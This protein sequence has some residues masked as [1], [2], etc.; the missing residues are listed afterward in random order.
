MSLSR[1]GVHAEFTP[2]FPWDRVHLMHVATINLDADTQGNADPPENN[3]KYYSKFQNAGDDVSIVNYGLS[4][5][6]LLPFFDTWHTFEFDFAANGSA[7]VRVDGVLTFETVAGFYDYNT[8]NEFS[9]LLGGR[10]YGETVNLYDSIS[11]TLVPEPG[12]GMLLLMGLLGL[13][14][15]RRGRQPN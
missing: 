3:Y 8:D 14:G 12:T 7:Q 2:A 5:N 10:S 15:Y 1:D 9:V 6:D 13:A 11:V 4:G